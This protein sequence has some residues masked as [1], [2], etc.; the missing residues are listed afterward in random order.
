VTPQATAIG[1]GETVSFAAAVAHGSSGVTWAAS[2]GTIDAHGIFVAPS[3]PQSVTININATSKDDPTKSAVA[4]VNVVG[5]GQVTATTNR[6]VASY[7]ISP[8][9]A[10]VS[11]QF[12]LDTTY[13]LITWAQPVPS[14]GGLV[15]PFVAKSIIYGKTSV[16]NQTQPCLDHKIGLCAV[17]I[18]SFWVGLGVHSFMERGEELK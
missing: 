9:A 10:G 3:G 13:G 1:T 4:S 17:V 11:V 5:P 14:G 7:A 16:W 8:A 2:A 18:P 12:G 15:S 6:Q